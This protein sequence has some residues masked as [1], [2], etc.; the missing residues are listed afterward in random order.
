MI[1]ANSLCTTSSVED[2]DED[3]EGGGCDGG[4]SSAIRGDCWL[5]RGLRPSEEEEWRQSLV[6]TGRPSSQGGGDDRWERGG[7]EAKKEG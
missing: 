2:E 4:G 3:D 6:G 1:L 5:R 7:K